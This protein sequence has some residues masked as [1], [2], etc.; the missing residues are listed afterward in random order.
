MRTLHTRELLRASEEADVAA[1][2]RQVTDYTTAPVFHHNTDSRRGPPLVRDGHLEVTV[3]NT[4]GLSHLPVNAGGNVLLVAL[5]IL[6]SHTRK[7]KHKIA[8]LTEKVALIDVPLMSITSGDI[9]VVIDQG[10]AREVGRTLD[11]G[12]A[13]R[14]AHKLSEVVSFF[15]DAS[16][17]ELPNLGLRAS[18]TG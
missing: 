18:L 7:V 3:G 15:Q 17:T 2:E 5:G 14:V 16:A 12:L 4:S 6:A 11:D 13:S 10:D 9:K 8:D 1:E